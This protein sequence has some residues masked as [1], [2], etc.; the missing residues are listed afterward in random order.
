MASAA[1]NNATTSALSRAASGKRVASSFAG[2]EGEQ[3]AVSAATAA[4]PAMA[5]SVPRLK[6][7]G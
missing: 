7:T 4:K 5:V 6:N 1:R 3:A 2:G